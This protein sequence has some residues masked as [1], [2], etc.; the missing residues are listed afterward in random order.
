VKIQQKVLF[1]GAT[2]IIEHPSFKALNKADTKFGHYMVNTD[3]RLMDKLTEKTSAPWTFT[4][5][6]DDLNTMLLK[7]FGYKSVEC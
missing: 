2:Q 4:F 7:H 5:Q 1:H 6:P 3:H